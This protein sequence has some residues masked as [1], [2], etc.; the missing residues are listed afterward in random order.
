[1][2]RDNDLE[3]LLIVTLIGIVPVIWLALLFAPYVNGGLPNIIENLGVIL[4]DPY[5]IEFCKGLS[6]NLSVKT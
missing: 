5:H 6:K 4:E 1:M 3:S 2:K